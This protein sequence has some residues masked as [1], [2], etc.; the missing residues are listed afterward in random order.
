MCA[1]EIKN[2]KNHTQIVSNMNFKFINTNY[3]H[4]SN[5]IHTTVVPQHLLE[6]FPLCGLCPCLK[7]YQ[8]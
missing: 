4:R 5:G 3:V 7:T 6:H 1:G 8:K 2:N